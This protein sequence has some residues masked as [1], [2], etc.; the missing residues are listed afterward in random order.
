LK[1]LE[2]EKEKRKTAVVEKEEAT[3]GDL[4]MEMLQNDAS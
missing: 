1:R 4:E 2:E 3:G